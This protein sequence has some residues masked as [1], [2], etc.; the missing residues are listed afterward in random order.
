M[1]WQTNPVPPLLEGKNVHYHHIL[2]PFKGMLGTQTNAVCASELLFSMTPCALM[3]GFL[4][5][6]QTRARTSNPLVRSCPSP[7][8]RRL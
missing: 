5:A 6:F 1:I 3:A 4:L 8:P 7:T 2:G